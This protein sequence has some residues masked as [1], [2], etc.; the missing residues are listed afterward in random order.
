MFRIRSIF[1]YV[2]ASTEEF[3]DK[4][5]LLEDQSS[6]KWKKIQS[7]FANSHLESIFNQEQLTALKN[8]TCRGGTWSDNTTTK[9]LKL[10]YNTK[11][12]FIRIFLILA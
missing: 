11:R 8:G 6:Q 1:F 9:C 4:D 10:Y 5:L 12:F 2:P 7:S 3:E